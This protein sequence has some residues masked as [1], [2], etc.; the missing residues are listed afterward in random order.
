MSRELFGNNH[1]FVADALINLAAIQSRWG[2]HKEAEELNRQALSISESWYGKE[3]PELASNMITLA[4][5]LTQLGRFDEAEK[6][7]MQALD[8]NKRVYPQGHARTAF[9]LNELGSLALNR[10]KN[11]EAEQWFLQAEEITR[12]KFGEGHFRTITA[13]SNLASVYTRREEYARAEELMHDV[14]AGYAKISADHLNVGTSRVKLGWI[15]LYQNKIQQAETEAFAGLE[16]IKKQKNPNRARL[17]ETYEQLFE[18][19]KA[20]KD[21][22]NAAKYKELMLQHTDR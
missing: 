11:D 10:Q 1:T 8:I 18:I 6:L 4:Q 13:R 14:I 15:L 12:R 20:K 5:D 19:Y 22:A 16:I 17:R 21:D 3:H 9:A 7:L 2:H